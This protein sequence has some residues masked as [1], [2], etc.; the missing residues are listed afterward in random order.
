MK[1]EEVV[2]GL[3]WAVMINCKSTLPG[4]KLFKGCLTQILTNHLNHT[5]H[6]KDDFIVEQ[7][8]VVCNDVT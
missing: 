5:S 4:P 8:N 7:Y 1:F 6:D 2:F 3:M